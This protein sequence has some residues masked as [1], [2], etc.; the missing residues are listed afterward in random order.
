[1]N[2]HESELVELL[3]KEGFGEHYF[4][5]NFYIHPDSGPKKEMGLLW[6]KFAFGDKCQVAVYNPNL[7]LS[8][9]LD[10]IKT[11]AEDFFTNIRDFRYKDT[12][13]AKADPTSFVEPNSLKTVNG[14]QNHLLHAEETNFN[15]KT[16]VIYHTFDKEVESAVKALKGIKLDNYEMEQSGNLI[17]A[18]DDGVGRGFSQGY[19]N[20]SRFHSKIKVHDPMIQMMILLSFYEMLAHNNVHMKGVSCTRATLAD[21]RPTFIL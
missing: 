9:V 11:K 18:I 7:K 6:R 19:N 12:I 2:E 1:M 8:D 16:L 3:K 5:I 4:D 14:L 10:K 17:Q 20:S 15:K 13:G 21:F